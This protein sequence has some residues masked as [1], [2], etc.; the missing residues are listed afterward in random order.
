MS[1]PC[2]LSAAEARRL[3]GIKSLSPVEL[4]KSCLKRIA[5]VDPT[6]HAITAIDEERALAEASDAE[7][8]VM[9]S[10]AQLPVLHGL[11]VGIKDLEATAGLRTTRGSL[12]YAD[13]V[14][15]TDDPV[16]ANIRAA[17]GIVLCKTNTPEFGAGAN[18]TN[19]V[20]GATGNPFDPSKTCAGS[21]GGSAVALATGMVALASGSDL[22][23]SLRT[24]AAYCG[25]V[26]FRPS[27]GVVPDPLSTIA[28]NP[29]GVLGPMGRT[30]DDTHLLLRGMLDFDPG[31]PFSSIDAFDAGD[32]IAAADLASLRVAISVDL[33]IATVSMEVRQL[34]ADRVKRFAQVF[35]SAERRDPPFA[36]VHEAFG[37]LR[38]L[39]YHAAY[40]ELLDQERHRLGPNVI[41]NTELG[42]QL[43][44]AEISRAHRQ[45]T[46]IYRDTIGFFREVDILIAPAAAVQPFPHS[47][48]FVREIDGKAMPNYVRWLALA[49]GP[50]TALCCVCCIP[51]GV[52]GNGLPFGIQVVGA[53]GA[54][55]QVLAAAKALEQLFAADR[56]L[57]RPLPDLSRLRSRS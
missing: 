33:G 24:P 20:F 27:P 23:G 39:S 17:G 2:D 30:V 53:K 48:P 51:C 57:A 21:S 13:D 4:V 55:S 3:I 18:T 25:V 43:T 49:Y 15:A 41:A 11:P 31:D 50:T 44:V 5:D 47:E 56:S 38:A 37:T 7:A 22:G 52:D 26:G 40:D 29:M 34:F 6:L 42:R 36:D 8:A 46:R 14:P 54:D 45:Q 12:V 16:V 19:R 35:R 10:D 28:L 9:A 1:E 32:P